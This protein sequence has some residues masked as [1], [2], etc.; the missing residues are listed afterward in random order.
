[1][2]NISVHCLP[3][4]GCPFLVLG[5]SNHIFQHLKEMKKIWCN[6]IGQNCKTTCCL[7]GYPSFYFS[8]KI[9]LV[10]LFPS[11]AIFCSPFSETFSIFVTFGYYKVKLLVILNMDLFCIKRST[12][13]Y[14]LKNY[15]NVVES[16]WHPF[17]K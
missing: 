12:I 5:F 14:I 9:I 16:S 4:V 13:N 17:S 7:S 15:M 8:P 10:L 6:A 11:K 1:M 2:Y 3:P